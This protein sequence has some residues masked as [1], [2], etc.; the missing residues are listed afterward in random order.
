[1]AC[2]SKISSAIGYDCDAGG[3][4]LISALLIN[5]EDIASI[6]FES[7]NPAFV[8]TITLKE[9]AS[10]YKI[11]TVNKFLMQ[12]TDEKFDYDDEISQLSDIF[13]DY[14]AFE[15]GTLQLKR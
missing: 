14:E 10:A 7:T 15:N 12:Q 5:K 2:I 9:G 8:T 13:A 11:D 3:T 4:G 1:M 6:V